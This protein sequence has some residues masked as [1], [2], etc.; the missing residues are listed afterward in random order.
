MKKSLSLSQDLD[1]FIYYDIILQ[2]I[3]EK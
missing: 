3:K 2:N 1:K